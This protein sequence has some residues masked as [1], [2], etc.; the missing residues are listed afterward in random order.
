[1][2]REEMIEEHCCRHS[3]QH[4]S[5]SAVLHMQVEMEIF[6]S[7][8]VKLLFLIDQHRETECVG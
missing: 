8:E 2:N 3:V 6:L 1:M 4:L 7:E 5:S